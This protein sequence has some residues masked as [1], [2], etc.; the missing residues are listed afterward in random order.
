MSDQ[1]TNAARRARDLGLLA[2]T[3]VCSWVATTAV[4]PTLAALGLGARRFM[5]G[6]REGEEHEPKHPA[7]KFIVTAWNQGDF[8]EAEK[9]VAPVVA[10]SVNG[11]T[12]DATPATGGMGMAQQSVEYWRSMVPTSRWRC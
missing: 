6:R 7:V 8:S 3:A 4:V 5:S 10:V 1:P 2:G 12:R 9:H 11:D